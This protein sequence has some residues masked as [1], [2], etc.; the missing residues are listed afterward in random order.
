M[1]RVIKVTAEAIKLIQTDRDYTKKVI[2][3]WMP[4]K[5]PDLLEQAYL[6]AQENY[7]RE[8]LV[9]EGALRSMVKQMVQSNLIDAKTSG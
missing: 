5:D 8:G 6:F 3:K 4:M 1:I 9:N 7:S 2:M